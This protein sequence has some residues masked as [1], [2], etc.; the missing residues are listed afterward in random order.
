MGAL[1]T[2]IAPI[3][4][5]MEP[6]EPPRL[7]IFIPPILAQPPMLIRSEI[8]LADDVDGVREYV[9]GN[10]HWIMDELLIR[11]GGLRCR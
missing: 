9:D 8:K 7:L 1:V 5:I 3:P 10:C 2:P 11:D 6:M 4:P